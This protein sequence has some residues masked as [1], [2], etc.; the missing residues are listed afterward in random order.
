MKRYLL[1]LVIFLVLVGFFAVGLNLN[2]REVPSPLIGKPAPVFS[3]PR[4]DDASKKFSAQDMKGKVWVV[5]VWASWCAPCRQEHVLVTEMAKRGGVP[6]VGL[7]Y[8]DQPANARAWLT[9]L[10]N[11]YAATASDLEGL[12]GI[13]FGVY[14]VP[15]TFVID[16]AGVIRF[17]H[18]GPL[19]AEALQAQILPMLRK[20]GA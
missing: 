12:V 18:I 6:V 3:L 15:E 2:P 4:L 11:P 1:P 8:K 7:N 16:Q 13:D 20:L 19:T 17:K 14:G 10:G 9:E 5:N